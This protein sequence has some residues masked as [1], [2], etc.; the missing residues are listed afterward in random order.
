MK[1]VYIAGPYTAPTEEGI[2]ENV[3]RAKNLSKQI[4][5]KGYNV[6]CPHLNYQFLE[7]EP[8]D[9]IMGGCLSLMVKSDIVYM[10]DGWCASHGA[11]IE[12]LVAINKNI[13]VVNNL[14]EL[15]RWT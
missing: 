6:I 2:K 5:E 7:G 12:R 15:A 3:I 13:P 11:N 8:Y 10:T 4:W 1:L 14:T 9:E